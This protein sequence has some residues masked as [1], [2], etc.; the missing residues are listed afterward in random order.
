VNHVVVSGQKVLLV[1]T[2]ALPTIKVQEIDLRGTGSEDRD[3]EPRVTLRSVNLIGVVRSSS[4]V[5]A[6]LYL[7]CTSSDKTSLVVLNLLTNAQSATPKEGGIIG[8][9]QSAGNGQ[10]T[11]NF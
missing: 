6:G 8:E 11:F 7:A 5:T 10:F 2:K 4:C 3:A 9:L 1:E